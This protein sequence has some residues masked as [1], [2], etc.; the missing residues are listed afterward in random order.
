[1]AG[2]TTDTGAD[3]TVAH[4]DRI[5]D[6]YASLYEQADTPAGYSFRVRRRRVLELFDRV[7]GR[8]LDVGCGPGV[9]VEAM[10]ER[11]C[12]FFGVDPAFGM[13]ELAAKRYR[14]AHAAHFAVAAAEALDHPD[15]VFDAVICTG[16]LERIADDDVALR[17]MVRVLKPGGSLILS[18]PNRW[19]PT[20]IWRDH[21]FYPVV[22][23]LRPIY[24][25]V[26]RAPATDVIRGHRRYSRRALVRRLLDAG[27]EVDSSVYLGFDLLPAPLNRPLPGLTLRLMRA[28]ERLSATP[29]RG[30]GAVLVVRAHRLGT[31]N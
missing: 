3:R 16:V 20:L 9:L 18:V 2:S 26:R 6:E 22:A 24:R 12:T 13:V 4:F 11:G 29:L 7:G 14:V 5:A 21:V 10:A 31:A 30:T 19:S 15:G 25:R 17:E 8:V 1:M 23:A 27:C 28:L